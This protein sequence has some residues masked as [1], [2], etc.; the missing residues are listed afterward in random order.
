MKKIEEET[1]IKFE[2]RYK[3]YLKELV[4]KSID[5]GSDFFVM[6]SNLD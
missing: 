3:I 1:C 6:S 4:P 2:D 5:H